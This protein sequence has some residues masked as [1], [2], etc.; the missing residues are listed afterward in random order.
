MKERKEAQT[1]NI[2]N[3]KNMT[4]DATYIKKKNMFF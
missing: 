1:S 2:R 3:G 4:T